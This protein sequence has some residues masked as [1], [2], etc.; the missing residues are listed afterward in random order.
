MKLRKCNNC[1]RYTLKEICNYCGSKTSY[2]HPPRYSPEDKFGEFRRKTLK[3]IESSQK[4]K[5]LL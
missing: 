1:K 3:E 5:S 2:P 4:E